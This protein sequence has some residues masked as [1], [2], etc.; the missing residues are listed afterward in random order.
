MSD[1]TIDGLVATLM[2]A[3]GE[4]LT[5]E[6]ER[7]VKKGAVNVK[8]D[9]RDNAKTDHGRAGKAA[10]LYPYSITFDGPV[11]KSGGLIEAEIGPDKNKRQGSL[12]NLLEY[13]SPH[14]AP[15][16]DGKGAGDKEL[17]NLIRNLNKTVAGLLW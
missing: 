6:V 12:G 9:W 11:R 16:E 2:R 17:P 15:R 1:M 3:G 5:R 13:G 7:V 4:Q 14:S 8:K 10:P